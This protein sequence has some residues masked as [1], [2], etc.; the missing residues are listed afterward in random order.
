MPEPKMPLLVD[1]LPEPEPKWNKAD[2]DQKL[3]VEIFTYPRGILAVVVNLIGN[4]A[5][6][7]YHNSAYIF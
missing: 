3:R 4:V 1:T 5:I 2:Y 6:K 7:K